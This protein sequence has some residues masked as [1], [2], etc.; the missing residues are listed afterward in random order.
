MKAKVG[1]MRYAY[2]EL[3]PVCLSAHQDSSRWQSPSNWFY[4]KC[5]M[6]IMFFIHK[7]C[8][9]IVQWDGNDLAAYLSSALVTQVS[10]DIVLDSIPFSQNYSAGGFCHWLGEGRFSGK[11]TWVVSPKEMCLIVDSI[12]VKLPA[13]AALFKSNYIQDIWGRLFTQVTDVTDFDGVNHS[14]WWNYRC[15]SFP[16]HPK[17]LQLSK[18]N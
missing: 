4:V 9:T 17:V 5:H 18:K 15:S 12:Y 8:L 14:A 10:V 7:Q 3:D 16:W 1:I 11:K 2:L 13:D 6:R